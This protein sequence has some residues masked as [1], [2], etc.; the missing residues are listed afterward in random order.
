MRLASTVL[1]DVVQLS[2]DSYLLFVPKG[3]GVG[4]GDGE[5]SHFTPPPRKRIVVGHGPIAP[6]LSCLRA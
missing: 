3:A 4:V 2:I 1:G 6:S 5:E